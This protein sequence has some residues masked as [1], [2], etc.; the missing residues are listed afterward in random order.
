MAKVSKKS[1]E[2]EKVKAPKKL[3]LLNKK[4]NVNYVVRNVKLM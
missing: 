2:K 4:L 1:A 3:E